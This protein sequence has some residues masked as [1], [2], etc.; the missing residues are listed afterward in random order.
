MSH[1]IPIKGIQCMA[2]IFVGSAWA[3]IN[4][5]WYLLG[6][7]SGWPDT[8]SPIGTSRMEQRNRTDGEQE[9]MQL[10]I[11]PGVHFGHM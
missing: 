1:M 11:G 7:K 4:E 8:Q 6:N 10:V 3:W 9:L 5:K 2:P